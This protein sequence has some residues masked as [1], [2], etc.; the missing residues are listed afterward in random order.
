MCVYVNSKF[1]STENNYYYMYI[2]VCVC[3]EK[4]AREM[5]AEASLTMELLKSTHT[6]FFLYY[7]M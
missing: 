3:D 1:I 5:K 2:Y 6:R 4:L 7:E